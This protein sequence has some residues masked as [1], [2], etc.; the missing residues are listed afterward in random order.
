[1]TRVT[2]EQKQDVLRLHFVEHLSSR[3][4]AERLGMAR[5]TV[6]NILSG[7]RT[8]GT[9]RKKRISQLGAYEAAIKQE[10]AR[11]PTM[12]APAMLERLRALGY[13]GGITILRDRMRRAAA[14]AA[15]RG[16]LALRLHP[17]QRCRST[18]R[19][20]GSRCR[21][22][23][24]RVGVRRGA[25]LLADAVCDLCAHAGDGHVPALHGARPAFL[26]RARQPSTSSTT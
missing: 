23:A 14:A 9:P 1:M 18:G 24:P 22:A 6:R 3:R 20:S 16:L 15:H 2:D 21:G 13:T 4:I 10:L 25:V 11:V 12:N 26:R 8:L 7:R 19:T 5:R 17:A